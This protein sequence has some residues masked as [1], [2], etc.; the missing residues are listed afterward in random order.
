[1]IA[2]YTNTPN[3][4]LVKLLSAL[5]T[6]ACPA[7]ALVCGPRAV[8]IEPGHHLCRRGNTLLS[9]FDASMSDELYLTSM[10]V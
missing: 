1:M 7:L 6:M 8:L 5:M 10:H 3:D 9:V 4:V 2:T